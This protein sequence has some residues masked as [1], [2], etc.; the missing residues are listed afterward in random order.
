MDQNLFFS[1]AFQAEFNWKNKFHLRMGSVLPQNKQQISNG[2]RDLSSE[3]IRYRFLGSKR[4]FTEKE[5]E[6]LTVLDGRNH[7]AVGIEETQPTKRGIAIVRLVRSSHSQSEAELA[8]TVIDE[9]QK[10]GLG[11]LLLDVI[12]L[13]AIERNIEVLSFTFLPQNKSI[14]K[15][16]QAFGQ[17]IL[18]A[19]SPDYSQLLLHLKTLDIEN[20]K[21]RLS[22]TLPVIETFHLKT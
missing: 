20:I 16:I 1:P 22:K 3:T 15:L 18:G 11:T 10:M 2:L 5:L 8:I 9:Y 19:H 13:A 17:P 7:Y 14:V 4:D 21:S 12:I 6:Y